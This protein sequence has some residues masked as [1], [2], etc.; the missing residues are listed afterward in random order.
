M[1]IRI[2]SLSSSATALR[3]ADSHPGKKGPSEMPQANAKIS[4]WDYDYIPEYNLD[5][6]IINAFLAGIFGNYQFFVSVSVND[7]TDSPPR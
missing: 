3:L 1:A 6:A 2:Y 5:E 4:Q 7:E